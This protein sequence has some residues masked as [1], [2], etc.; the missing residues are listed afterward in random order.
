MGRCIRTA[1]ER[2]IAKQSRFVVKPCDKDGVRQL[3]EEE[4]ENVGAQT[5]V[6]WMLQW[7]GSEKE[8]KKDAAIE[9]AA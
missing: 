3:K 2:L 4:L 8:G 6:D 9:T 1:Q 7:K 5:Q